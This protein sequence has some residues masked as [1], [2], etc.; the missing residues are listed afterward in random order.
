VKLFF[1]TI[2]ELQ[3]F[4]DTF[5]VDLTGVNAPSGG[6]HPCY[7]PVKELMPEEMGPD[8]FRSLVE[9]CNNYNAETKFVL[10]VAV[11][12]WSEVPTP[13]NVK[14]E[15]LLIVKCA[16]MRLSPMM[17]PK[18]GAGGRPKERHASRLFLNKIINI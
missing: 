2:D 1:Q 14:F 8:N 17:S 18:H 13:E 16:K 9:L 7:V 6:A 15:R 3:D 11:C 4:L 5:K 12:V 10:Y